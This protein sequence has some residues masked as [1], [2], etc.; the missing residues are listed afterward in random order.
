[1][2]K[3]I[4]AVT[5]PVAKMPAE[6][7]AIG[8]AA[9]LEATLLAALAAGNAADAD[10][11]AAEAVERRTDADVLLRLFDALI[12]A[13]MPRPAMLVLEH[14]GATNQTDPA[15]VWRTARGVAAVAGSQAA[16]GYLRQTLFPVPPADGG[17]G[18]REAFYRQ[19]QELLETRGFVLRQSELIDRLQRAIERTQ[20]IA[21]FLGSELRH[22]QANTAFATLCNQW[23]EPFGFMPPSARHFR[24]LFVSGDSNSPSHQYRVTNVIQGLAEHGVEA[25]WIPVDKVEALGGRLA[26]YSLVVFWRVALIPVIDRITAACRFANVPVVYDTDDYVFEPRV[27]NVKY[28]DGIRFL[29]AAEMELYEWG[30]K[31]YR[32]ML[33]RCQFSTF[34]TPFLAARGA[35]LGRTSHVI[36]NGLDR[37]FL[38][39][40]ALPPLKRNDDLVM[41]GYTPGSRTHQRDFRN[42]A[43]A[44]ARVLAE[45]PKARFKIVG[46]F[47]PFE[48]PE[49]LAVSD[50]ILIDPTLGREQLR[51]KI[52]TFDINIAPLELNN[53]FTEA[54]SEL[55]YFEPACLGVPTVA[56]PTQVF[57]DSIEPGITGF[58]A[59]TTEEWYDALTKLVR[60]H[61][62]RHRVAANAKAAVLKTYDIATLGGVAK[63]VYTDIIRQF[64]AGLGRT[65]GALT[66]SM[67]LPKLTRGSGGHAKAI[68]MM[69]GLSNLGHDVHLHFTE[70]SEDFPTADSVRQEYNLLSS[71]AVSA[72]DIDL[73]PCDI[74]IATFWKTAHMLR[75]RPSI[76]R[77]RAYLMQ[78]YEPLFYPMSDDYVGAEQSYRLGLRNISYGPWI[79]DKIKRDL[80]IDADWIPFF[81]DKATFKADLSAKRPADRLVVFN[82]P[83]MPRRL[84]N[85]TMEGIRRFVEKTNFTGTIDL[86]G[87]YADAHIPF[88]HVNHRV[89]SPPEMAKLFRS[90]TVGIAISSTNPSMVPF[91][92]MACG[93][94]VIDIDYGGNAINYGGAE[95]AWLMPPDPDAFADGIAALLDSPAEMERLSANGLGFIAKFPDES[96]V[97]ERLDAL[98]QR[99]VGEEKPTP[100]EDEDGDLGIMPLAV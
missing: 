54:K 84:F 27:A 87:S 58:L 3:T 89:I 19:G 18:L 83:E 4:N 6:P 30:V 22:A 57:V 2:T 53:P 33:L 5:A 40:A 32:A 91:E 47:D 23:G 49:F 36:R 78:D 76:A 66:I 21:D 64:R 65:D 61:K 100:I 80:D 29:P 59:R 86:F 13:G 79:R 60:D 15:L 90:G 52:R 24:I 93:L 43:P 46:D 63:T 50:Q 31:A 81:I 7:Q 12:D 99:Y 55:K 97:I 95:N 82:R 37:R 56:T 10:R 88:P 94:P 62:L 96:D 34:S 41:I 71:V 72:G 51:E 11:V 1:M 85:L 8:L 28:V 75:E 25:D 20:G 9:D 26:S 73:R 68:S 45:N 98:L 35:E 14:L 70:P 48:Y 16:I 39:M 67:L 44:V 42:A 69:R 77:V 74:A 92:M 17:E 38:E